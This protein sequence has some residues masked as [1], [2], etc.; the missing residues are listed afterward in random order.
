MYRKPL[1]GLRGQTQESR[2]RAYTREPRER[3]RER[4]RESWRKRCGSSLGPTNERGVWALLFLGELDQWLSFVVKLTVHL[5][6]G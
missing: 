4:E 1:S 2:E 5:L 6:V 3:V